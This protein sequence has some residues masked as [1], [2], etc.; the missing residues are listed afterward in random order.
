M[1]PV[2]EML[3][4]MVLSADK[5][6]LRVPLLVTSPDPNEPVVEPLPTCKVPAEIVL[7]P[8]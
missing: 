4:A 5:S 2:P 7:M 8:V 6:N 1:A 3:L